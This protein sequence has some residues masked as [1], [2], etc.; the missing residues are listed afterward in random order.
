MLGLGKEMR[1]IGNEV[2]EVELEREEGTLAKKVRII[3]KCVYRGRPLSPPGSPPLN[4]AQ[5]DGSFC[6][7]I[8]DTPLT[9]YIPPPTVSAN[10][11][12]GTNRRHRDMGD[13][14]RHGPIPP[15]L[16]RRRAKENKPGAIPK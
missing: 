11:F 13:I 7:H 1:E 2:E 3:A 12:K 16:L 5:D 8:Q 4:S 6:H 10:L 14:R 9:G 15:L